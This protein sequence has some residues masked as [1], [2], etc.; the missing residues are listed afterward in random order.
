MVAFVGW[1]VGAALT[2]GL[3]NIHAIM[4]ALVMVELVVLDSLDGLVK[5]TQVGYV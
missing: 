3:L 5:P 2:N 1:Q 4:H